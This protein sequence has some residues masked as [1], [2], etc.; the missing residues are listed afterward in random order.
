[1]QPYFYP[2]AGYFRLLV[3][4][5]VF[6]IYDCVQFPRRGRVHRCEVPGQGGRPQ[7]VPLPLMRQPRS[8]LI[9]ELSF[10]AGAPA[11]L[12]R[13][14]VRLGWLAAAQGPA[15]EIIRQSLRIS[16]P[17]V[18]DYLEHQ[19]RLVAS[20]LGFQPEFR[21]SSGLAI[22]ADL[23][24]QDRV[25]A[26]ARAV[27]GTHYVNAP[28]GRDL[29]RR[30]AFLAAGIELGFLAPYGGPFRY[31]LQALTCEDPL[32]IS[33]DIRQSSMIEPA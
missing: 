10:A 22:P 33:R 3:A 23:C 21:R 26:I 24:G 5:D 25:I 2:Y 19:I 12:D 14:I 8:T 30:E 11:E 32:R 18:C 4:A 7:C 15:A 29:Y 28:G 16:G 27:G 17:C 9:R 13:R 20:I 1:M 31:M 6:V